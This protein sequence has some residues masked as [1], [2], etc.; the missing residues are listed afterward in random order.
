ADFSDV[1]DGLGRFKWQYL[2]LVL[3]LTSLNYVL[4]F[5]KWQFYL[6]TIGVEGFST[7]DCALTYYAGLGMVVTP[8]K[9]GEWLKCYLLRELHGTPFSRSAPIVIAERL[10]DSFAMVLLGSVGLFVYRDSWPVF[11]LIVVGGTAMF[12]V[13]RNRKL[14]FWILHK[15]EGLPV[16]SR[17]AKHA[18]EFYESTYALMSPASV[19]SMTVLSFFSWG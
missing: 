5:F 7:R 17:F 19:L 6:K 4:R 18:E 15:L 8:G 13:A 1:I 3:L 14:S 10:T 9:V 16:V 11:V 2:P 12:Y